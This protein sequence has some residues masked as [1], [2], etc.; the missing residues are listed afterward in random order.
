MVSPREDLMYSWPGPRLW[1]T[2]T[3]LKAVTLE[4][5]ESK[6]RSGEAKGRMNCNRE[7]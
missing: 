7:P 2:G 5:G 1:E 6:R 3:R 4:G